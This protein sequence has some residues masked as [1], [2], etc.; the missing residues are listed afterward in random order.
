M[1]T[2]TLQAAAEKLEAAGYIARVWKDQR[3]YVT[4][5]GRELGYITEHDL[6]GGTGTCKN[7]RRGGHIARILRSA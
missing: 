4:Q 2:E 3:V 7:V 6:S 1:T 5:Q